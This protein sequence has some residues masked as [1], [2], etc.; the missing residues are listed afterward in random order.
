MKLPLLA[1]IAGLA[2]FTTSST[3]MAGGEDW[4]TDFSAA[5]AKAAKENKSLLVDFTGSDWCGWCIRL[6]EEVFSHEAF[7]KGVAETFVLVELDYPQDSSK[8]PQATQEQNQKLKDQYKIQGFPT[9]LLMNAEGLPFAKTGYQQGGPENYVSHLNELRVTGGTI[10][11]ALASAKQAEG[12]EKAKAYA[13]ALKLVP[14]SLLDYY[15]GIEDQLKTLDPED[16]TGYHAGKE[17]AKQLAADLS[18]LRSDVHALS[19]QGKATEANTLID[20]FVAKN[21]LNDEQQEQL[22]MLK[23][24][25]TLR[26]IQSEVS[27]AEQA[28]NVEGALKV[29]DDYILKH[30]IKGAQK[31]EILGFKMATLFKAK[32]FEEVNTLLDEVIAIDPNSEIAQVVKELKAKRLPQMIEDAKKA[33]QSKAEV[34]EKAAQ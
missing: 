29:I 9:I 8:I 1:C 10:N 5:K 20:Q 13:S 30:G 28:G 16:T 3:L 15:T 11:T 23:K 31:Q 34:E 18:K 2:T 32:R 26:G 6:N 12:M 24:H 22:A 27:A 17:A 33:D 19:G 4:M 14:E 7:K 25:V 21:S